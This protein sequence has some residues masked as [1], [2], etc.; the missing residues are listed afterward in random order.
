MKGCSVPFGGHL[1]RRRAALV[2]WLALAVAV[3]GVV[4]YA[5]QAD[6]YQAHKAELN[7]G[8][9]WVTSNRDGSYGRINKPIGELDGTIFSRARL[10]PRHRPGRLVGRRHQPVRRGRGPARPRPDA[11]AGRRGGLDPRQPRGRDGRRQPRR[12]RHRVR[13]AVGHPRG[14]GRRVPRVASLA[15][16]SEPLAQSARTPRS[17][18]PSTARVYAVSAAEDQ[19][20]T[21]AQQGDDRLRRRRRPTTCPATAFSDA[22]A[23]TAVGAT[24]VVLDSATGRL[25]VVGGA[26]AAGAEGLGAP[27][28]GTERR[29]RCWSPRRDALLSVDL[30]TGEVTTLADGVGGDPANPVRL[31]DC[32]YGA[33]AGGTGA[34]VTVVRRRASRDAAGPRRADL[35]PGLPHQPRAD[36]AQRPR[37]RPRLGHRLRQA[38]PARQLGRLPPQVQGRGRRRRRRARRTRATGGRRR[39]RTTTSA[40]GPAAPRSCT[41]STTTPHRRAGCSRSARCATSAGPMPSSRSA[42]TARPCRSRC[43]TTPWA[44]P[45]SST[46]STTGGSRSPPTPRSASRSPA[47][48]SANSEPAPA[49][50]ASSRGCGPSRRRHASTSPCSPTGATPRTATPSRP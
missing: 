42:P 5:V 27:A 45:A 36:R 3:S 50:R 41:R 46:S 16:Q 24:P 29:P 15:D 35:R 6:G 1:Q 43:P 10:Q 14:P 38:H 33:W 8:G 12:A 9:I 4:A 26:E 32:R 37:H 17:R 22:I 7:D 48:A 21:L 47:P 20:L 25:T 39:P 34:V 18:S 2:S 11:G 49:R 40:P 28:A 44:A 31:G 23:L 19:L 30:A 13:P